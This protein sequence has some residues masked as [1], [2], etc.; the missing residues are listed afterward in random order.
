MPIDYVFDAEH[1]YSTLQAD[2]PQLHFVNETDP[3]IPPK[4]QG[5]PLKVKELEGTPT[6]YLLY[7][8]LW[9]TIF[10]N[11]LMHYP[12][13]ITKEAPARVSFNGEVQ[14]TWP[15]A[16]DGPNFKRDWGLVAQ[17]SRDIRELG[18]RI[19]YQLYQQAGCQQDPAIISTD[20]FLGVH[21][22]TEADAAAENWA[23][24]E[25]Q[26]QRIQEQLTTSQL[27]VLYVASGNRNDVQRLREDVAGFQVFVNGVVQPLRIVEKWDLANEADT[28][29]MGQLTWDQLAIVD[30]EVM[31]RASR[32]AGIS[33]SSWTWMVALTR[34][35]H[36]P[37]ED[38]YEKGTVTYE[39]GLSVIYGA[40]GDLPMIDP[41]IF[42]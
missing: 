32:F 17:F 16:Y 12:T 22:R 39:D 7:P 21:L 8:E 18:A 6:W 5:V 11:W 1:F 4:I 36:V 9:R 23:S 37:E 31:L 27:A 42:L 20:C 2:C 19:L 38:P 28:S 33:S 3:N 41:T 14:F 15:T 40:V 35:L 26:L 13:P 25:T 29:L 24:Y 34:H 30:L 10:D